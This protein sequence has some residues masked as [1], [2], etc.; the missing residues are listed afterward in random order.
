MSGWRPISQVGLR[1]N[2][3]QAQKARKV[4]PVDQKTDSDCLRASI[5]SIF[6]LNLEDVP[7]FGESAKDVEHSGIVQDTDLRKWLAQHGISISPVTNPETL[8][9]RGA[10]SARA[11]WGFCVGGGKSPR[12]DWDHSVVYDARE[13]D[14]ALLHDPHPSRAGLEGNPVYYTCF[15]LEDPSKW[16]AWSRERAAYE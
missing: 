14:P 9:A 10:K 4:R 3:N 12:G 2:K 11:P 7:Y 8:F 6:E 1:K 16:R 5:A 15:L 13:G